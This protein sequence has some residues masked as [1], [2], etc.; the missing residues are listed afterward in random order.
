MHTAAVGEFVLRQARFATQALQVQSEPEYD[1]ALTP[2]ALQRLEACWFTGRLRDL[3]E[4][5][6]PSTAACRAGRGH[7]YPYPRVRLQS[8]LIR[9]E[10][11]SESRYQV[12]NCTMLST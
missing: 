8:C 7:R 10:F 6:R 3:P 11:R 5:E 9:G 12:R 4:P 2:A 1:L